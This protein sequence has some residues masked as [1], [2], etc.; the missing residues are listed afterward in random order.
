MPLRV[1]ILKGDE[2]PESKIV[3]QNEILEVQRDLN[4]SNDQLHNIV[5]L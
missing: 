1:K 5:N 4:I 2:A 3:T